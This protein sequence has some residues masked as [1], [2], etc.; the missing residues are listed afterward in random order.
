MKFLV[1]GGAGFIGSHLACRLSPLG[2][3]IVLDDLTSGRESNLQGIPCRRIRGSILDSAKLN[4]ALQGVSHVFH[5]AAMVSVPK[6]VQQPALCHNINVEGT[7]RVLESAAAAGVKR[8]VLASSCA[9]Y[10][11]EP[12]LPKT[13]DL[14]PTPLSPYALSKWEGEKLCASASLPAV[15]LRFFNVYGPRQDPQGPYAAAVPKFLEAAAAGTPLTLHGDGL[16]TRDFVFV[17]DVTAALLHVATH[18]PCQG[19]YNVASGHSVSIL[20]LAQTIL[21]VTGSKSS[22]QTAPARA[23]D[24]RHSSAS[25]QRLSAT[26]WQPKFTLATGLKKILSS[27]G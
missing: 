14:P 4:E 17:E 8:L 25:I 15:A 11:N 21:A 26:G 24:V 6:S 10:G 9:V 1:T 20:E 19:V 3:V 23:A 5:L 7:R 2:E 13:E 27:A 16:Q 12:T 22:L 18:S